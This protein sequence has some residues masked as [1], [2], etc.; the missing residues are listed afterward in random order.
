MP[1]VFA[2][3][4]PWLLAAIGV[5]A[6]TGGFAA[7]GE[8]RRPA[9]WLVWFVGAAVAAG[10]AIALGAIEGVAAHG[11][12]VAV[13]CF[14]AFL[15]GAAGVSA[16]RNALGGHERWALGLVPLALL[17]WGAIHFA[18][19]VEA[20][21]AANPPP[22]QVAAPEPERPAPE[23]DADQT[24]A[25]PAPAAPSTDPAAIL[26]A[27]PAGALDAATCQRALDAVAAA[28][29]VVF[30]PTH[31]TIHRR[32]SRALDKAVEV[33]RRCP[34]ATIEVRG[35]DDGDGANEAL[36]LRRAR[37]A[38]RYLRDEGVGGRKL[39]V[40]AARAPRPGAGVIGYALR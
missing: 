2:P 25:I 37:A 21:R 16:A 7:R 36:S 27:L 19:P 15:A 38:E 23:R 18:P 17:Y 34:E 39:A 31:A 26:A 4:W 30:N 35:F 1:D 28:E 20:P 32:A 24:G 29:P 11:V 9:R 10:V 13:A 33:I 40:S 8:R 12:G 5:G 6:A 22:A 3:L 14:V